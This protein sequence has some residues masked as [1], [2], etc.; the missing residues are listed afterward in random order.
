M[1]TMAASTEVESRSTRKLRHSYNGV[2]CVAR[3]LDLD[4]SIEASRDT[5]VESR[6]TRKLRYSCNRVLCV[7]RQ[8]L[9]ATVRC[10]CPEAQFDVSQL[11]YMAAC[12]KYTATSFMYFNSKVRECAIK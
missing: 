11:L 12:T 2:L 10:S 7:A 4:L 5:E 8:R 3:Q 9:V 1:F 6:T